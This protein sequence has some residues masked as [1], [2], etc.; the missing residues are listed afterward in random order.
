[1]NGRFDG[2]LVKLDDPGSSCCGNVSD[3]A[4]CLVRLAEIL[5]RRP[6]QERVPVCCEDVDP[7]QSD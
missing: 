1:M 7:R 6:F 4:D 2:R 5:K 3:A